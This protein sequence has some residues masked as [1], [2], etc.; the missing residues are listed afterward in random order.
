AHWGGR[1][2]DLPEKFP[3]FVTAFKS[4]AHF[5]SIDQSIFEQLG[6]KG[7]GPLALSMV[8]T[9]KNVDVLQNVNVSTGKLSE[10]RFEDS[11]PLPAKSAVSLPPLE[12]VLL[13]GGKAVEEWL[14]SQGLQR[15]Q[16]LEVT[17]DACEQYREHW[18]GQTPLYMEDPPYARI[19]G[20]HVTWPDDD[21]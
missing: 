7:R 21:F 6:L 9:A 1:R 15:W 13:Y 5:L 19:G 4:Q 20:W 8:T 16:Y 12:A 14:A 10:V 3:D 17:R 2:S 18:K 11:I